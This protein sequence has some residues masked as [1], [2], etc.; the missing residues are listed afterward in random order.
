MAYADVGSIRILDGDLDGGVF[1]DDGNLGMLQVTNGNVTDDGMIDARVLV[2]GVLGS[3][4]VRGGNVQDRIHADDIG[5]VQIIGSIDATG[6]VESLAGIGY[7]Y[8]S[9]GITGAVTADGRIGTLMAAGDVSGTVTGTSL[10]SVYVRGNL[11]GSALT[12]SVGGLDTL[13]VTGE[14]LNSSIS[15]A[16]V[17]SRLYVGGNFTNS[18][19]SA[20][21]LSIITVRGQITGMG[22]EEIVA[23]TGSFTISDADERRVISDAV[24]YDFSGVHAYVDV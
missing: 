14:M 1:V 11:N 18:N 4:V 21:R 6:E 20:G 3:M 7:L 23:S 10:G 5:R 16:G 19:V 9:N 17:L 8:V 2:D 24:G 15:A 12:A 22:V 13:N